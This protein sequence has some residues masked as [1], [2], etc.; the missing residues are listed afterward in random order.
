[1][2]FVSVE[3]S[4]LCESSSMSIFESCLSSIDVANN[5]VVGVERDFLHIRNPE[6]A[7][8]KD[9]AGGTPDDVDG[10]DS[11]DDE[12]VSCRRNSLV[13]EDKGETRDSTTVALE[14]KRTA[15]TA[16]T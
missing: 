7:G 11:T 15:A 14:R 16:I 10:D 1:M 9:L 2:L 13:D 12:T 3:T 4:S 8:V 6:E 5:E